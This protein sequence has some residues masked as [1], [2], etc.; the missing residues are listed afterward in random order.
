MR[1]QDRPGAIVR[2][3]IA[4]MTAHA[5]A[6]RHPLPVMWAN[7]PPTVERVAIR[8]LVLRLAAVGIDGTNPD[9]MNPWAEKIAAQWDTINTPGAQSRATQKGN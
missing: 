5:N 2:A 7:L 9:I 8:S 6:E 3:V 4:D 1:P